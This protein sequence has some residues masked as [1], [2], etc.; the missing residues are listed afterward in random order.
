MNEVLIP[1]SP[2]RFRTDRQ[3]VAVLDSGAPNIYLP[4]PEFNAVIDAFRGS[5]ATELN[6]AGT[7]LF[8]ECE[9]AQ[10]LELKICGQ[11]VAVDPLDVLKPQSQNVVNGTRMH[12]QSSTAY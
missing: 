8:F 6:E 10:L 1:L 12:V 7:K 4:M 3:H 11:W 2:G 9:K 5:T